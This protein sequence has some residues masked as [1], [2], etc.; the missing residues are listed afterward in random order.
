M[1]KVTRAD[2]AFS[3]MAHAKLCKALGHY[4]DVQVREPTFQTIKQHATCFTDIAAMVDNA[5]L[6]E[7]NINTLLNN[8]QRAD[9]QLQEL[10]DRGVDHRNKYGEILPMNGNGA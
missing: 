10:I 7:R 2:S 3:T 5:Q 4:L 9:K 8:L 6:A 1:N